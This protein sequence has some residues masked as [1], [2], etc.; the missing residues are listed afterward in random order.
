MTDMDDAI[1]LTAHVDVLGVWERDIVALMD[2]NVDAKFMRI[3][4]LV[5]SASELKRMERLVSGSATIDP[6]LYRI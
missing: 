5:H 1:H 6:S 2:E 4:F 3:G